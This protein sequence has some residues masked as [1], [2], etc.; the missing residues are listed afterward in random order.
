MKAI[1]QAAHA[2]HRKVAA[3]A[4]SPDEA[5]RAAEAGVD[6]VE[7]GYD[8]GDETLRLMAKSG[9]FLVPTDFDVSGYL[10]MAAPPGTPEQ[11]VAD[12]KRGFE[13]FAKANATRL[14]HAMKLGVKI[15]AGSDLYYQFPGRTRG[16]STAAMFSNYRNEG[17]PPLEI[18]RAATVNTAELLGWKSKVGTLQAGAWADIIAVEGNPLQDITALERVK[19]VMK[20][21]AVVRD[22]SHS[23]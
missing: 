20:G 23:H 17:M 2:V 9:T 21:G 7:H 18:I 3:H 16:Q 4:A 12:A 10:P 22:D 13:E 14:Q 19:F 15:V 11:H 8:V 6:S 5:Q 1:V